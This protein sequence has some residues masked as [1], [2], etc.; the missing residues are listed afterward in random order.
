MDLKEMFIFA[1]AAY[2][3]AS[4]AAG[5]PETDRLVA[6]DKKCDEARAAKLK[7]I[8][9]ALVEKCVNEEKRPRSVCEV[10]LSTY[11]DAHTSLANLSAINRQFEDLPEC[12]AARQGWLD[13]DRRNTR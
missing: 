11:G 9:A 10:E 6:Q 2:A 5:D 4:Y 12:V 13:R 3:V 7:P 1:L 8:R